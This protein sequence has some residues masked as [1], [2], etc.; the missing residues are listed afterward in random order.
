MECYILFEDL[1][2]IHE[3]VIIKKVLKVKRLLFQKAFAHI[4][5]WIGN[6]CLHFIVGYTTP[7]A[8]TVWE[9]GHNINRT[10][11]TLSYLVFVVN[12]LIRLNVTTHYATHPGW[13]TNGWVMGQKPYAHIWAYAPNLI[14]ISR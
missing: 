10:F 8:N 13:T 5:F 12:S 9:V 3:R 14:V 1:K 4:F 6:F 7:T 2:N 11:K